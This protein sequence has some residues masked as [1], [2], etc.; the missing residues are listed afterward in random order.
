[1]DIGGPAGDVE[2]AGDGG[3]GGVG[4]VDDPEGVDDEVSD[5]VGEVLVEAGGEETFTASEVELSQF[6]QDIDLGLIG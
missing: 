4:E 5:D 6:S 1:M 2:F 3:L